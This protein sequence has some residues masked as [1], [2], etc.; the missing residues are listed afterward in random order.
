MSI[1]FVNNAHRTTQSY[2][3]NILEAAKKLA[4][5]EHAQKTLASAITLNNVD[6]IRLKVVPGEENKTEEVYK[7]KYEQLMKENEALKKNLHVEKENNMAL[8]KQVDQR[9]SFFGIP[10]QIRNQESHTEMDEEC[11]DERSKEMLEE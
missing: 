11:D 5:N 1:D 2:Y 3:R 8:R 4:G 7:N 9:K 6:N 10:L